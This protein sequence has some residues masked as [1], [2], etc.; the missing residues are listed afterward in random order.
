LEKRLREALKV[1]TVRAILFGSDAAP[2]RPE[3]PLMRH[4]LD[5]RRPVPVDETL[6]SQR[7]EVPIDEAAWLNEHGIG[8]LIPLT[9]QGGL[10]GFLAIGWRSDGDEYDAEELRIL[11]S[12]TPQILLAGENARLLEENLEKKRLEEELAGARRIQESLLPRELPPTP[13][14]VLHHT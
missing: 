6:A 13:G 2:F 12:L 11:N 8:L 9:G 1:G 14:L 4:L 3:S 5:L 7:I 10:L